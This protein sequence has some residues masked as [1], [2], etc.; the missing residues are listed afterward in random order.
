MSTYVVPKLSEA[1]SGVLLKPKGDVCIQPA[2]L[3]L[4]CLGQV[5]VVERDGGRDSA[6][7]EGAQEILVIL[8]AGRVLR[9][10]SLRQ[11]PGPRDGEPAGPNLGILSTLLK[12]LIYCQSE[13]IL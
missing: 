2:A 10:G 4:E 1:D 3:V 13:P 5:P 8:D 7:L 6:G 12:M 11:D 9:P